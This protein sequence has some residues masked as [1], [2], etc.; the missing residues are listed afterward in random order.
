MYACCEVK[1]CAKAWFLTSHYSEA[2]RVR[3]D[4]IDYRCADEKEKMVKLKKRALY[5]YIGLDSWFI[6][7]IPIITVEKQTV[8]PGNTFEDIV[9]QVLFKISKFYIWL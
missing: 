9:F 3:H 2:T 1:E 5:R 8:E 7:I 4:G 6:Q